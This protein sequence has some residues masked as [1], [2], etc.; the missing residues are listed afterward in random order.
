MKHPRWVDVTRYQ[1]GDV[2]WHGTSMAYGVVELQRPSWVSDSHVVASW[3]SKWKLGSDGAGGVARVLKY[4]VVRP[5][6]LPSYPA[7][8]RN[9]GVG[10]HTFAVWAMALASGMTPDEI[11]D[12]ARS[13]DDIYGLVEDLCAAGHAGWR[14]INN[15]STGDDI[16]LCKPDLLLR[17]VP[18]GSERRPVRGE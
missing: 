18:A 2:L 11:E 4:E 9:S 5:F 14:I 16:L 6:T 7:H 8:G 12:E 1:V 17:R 13:P 15:Y 10:R 3:F